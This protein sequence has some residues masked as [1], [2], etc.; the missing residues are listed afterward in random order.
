MREREGKREQASGNRNFF[1]FP[2]GMCVLRVK[3]FPIADARM[4][5]RTRTRTTV[6]ATARGRERE[7]ERGDNNNDDSSKVQIK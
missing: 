3:V 5:T 7:R 4:R 2:D 6:T 1:H